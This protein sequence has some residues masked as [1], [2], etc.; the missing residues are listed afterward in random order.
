MAQNGTLQSNSVKSGDWEN[1]LR[2]A[3]RP[4][5]EPPPWIAASVAVFGPTQRTLNVVR[6]I[7][8]LAFGGIL[9]FVTLLAFLLLGHSPDGQS[10]LL[11]V[12]LFGL[13]ACLAAWY[14]ASRVERR[15]NQRKKQ[16]ERRMYGAGLHLDDDGRVRTDNPHPVLIL[17]PA[18]RKATTTS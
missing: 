4:F 1:A 3:A 17:D 16:I 13:P 18:A 6:S 7:R 11:I 15:L 8:A 14:V 9:V 5:K 2:G 10:V 12:S